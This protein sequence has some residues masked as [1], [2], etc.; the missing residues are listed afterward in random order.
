VA[1]SDSNTKLQHS[2]FGLST[3]VA[4]AV[5][6]CLTVRLPCLCL[7]A[8]LRSRSRSRSRS[9]ASAELRACRAAF[10]KRHTTEETKL[11]QLLLA[12]RPN[13]R[14]KPVVF[15]GRY[16]LLLYKPLDKLQGE[17]WL[18]HEAPYAHTTRS[19]LTYAM[20]FSL[21]WS[22][23]GAVDTAARVST[24]TGKQN[25][26][27]AL[28]FHWPKS[29]CH[30]VIVSRL[31]GMSFYYEIGLGLP[32]FDEGLDVH[33]VDDEHTNNFLRNLKVKRKPAHGEHHGGQRSN[34]RR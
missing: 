27:K 20:E 30:Q 14:G 29:G 22:K 32:R 8:M 28:V 33:H 31:V 4:Y 10:G 1:N 34:P 13:L 24:L 23:T 17:V 11:H 25:G 2:R 5:R 6:T 18:R 26:G 15:A 7:E 16:Y 19:G 21:W 12:V 9:P 3:R